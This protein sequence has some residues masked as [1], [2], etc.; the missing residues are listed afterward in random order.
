M[1]QRSLVVVDG[2][3]MD[4]LLSQFDMFGNV[5]VVSRRRD[6]IDSVQRF[7]G[8]I[9][10]NFVERHMQLLLLSDSLRD[11]QQGG[12]TNGAPVNAQRS[13][14]DSK[15]RYCTVPCP[16]IVNK[17]KLLEL[18]LIEPNA[19]KVR[20]LLVNL[21][22]LTW[23]SSFRYSTLGMRALRGSKGTLMSVRLLDLWY[24]PFQCPC[25]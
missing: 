5:A 23:P 10:G 4:A 18:V 6:G 15:A 2:S 20:S 22:Y 16:Q 9:G 3:N 12:L 25:T 17:P 14:P 8:C 1:K 7:G 19:F 13:R 21:P 24:V 11:D